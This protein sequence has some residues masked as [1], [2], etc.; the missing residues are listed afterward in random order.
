MP[1]KRR[2]SLIVWLLLGFAVLA[3]A[4]V[5]V[6]QARAPMAV[7]VAAVDRGPVALE[8]VDEGR[9]RVKEVFAVSAPVA[10]RLE[11]VALEPGDSVRAGDVVARIAP[12]DSV[13]LD[14][15]TTRE[16][17]AQVAAARAAVAEAETQLALAADELRRTQ[18]LIARGFIS[19]SGLERVKATERAAR[20]TLAARRAELT[21]AR[22]AL[23][24]G[25]TQSGTTL[26][27]APSAGVVLE[28]LQESQTVVAAGASLLTIGDPSST[29][30][31]GEFLS[32]D[33]VRIPP[34]AA[35]KVENW[36]GSPIDARVVRVEPF[37]RMKISAL[38]VE[39]QRAN[40]IVEMLESDKAARL[41]HGYRV[42]VRVAL[43]AQGDALRVPSDALIRDAAGWSVMR[44]VD[45]RARRTAVQVGDASGAFR[46]V[47]SG[48]S[49][50]DTIVRFPS[51]KLQDGGRVAPQSDG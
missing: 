23:Q 29:E 13:L 28:L 44:V 20:A 22:A 18:S 51:A 17:Q 4:A 26:V 36:G 10:G 50:G 49:D 27:R 24:P 25:S 19:E 3:A 38:G 1:K 11:R 46:P 31:V 8:I 5:L 41:G 7:Q 15:R 37:A 43:A 42:D 6:S 14:A 12:S 16:A 40:V 35:A 34:N 39:E 30:V 32:Q 45:G 48:L 2:I 47:T 21:R 9:V 33:A